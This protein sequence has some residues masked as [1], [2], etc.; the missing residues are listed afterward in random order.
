[1]HIYF[2]FICLLLLH[3]VYSV[4]PYEDFKDNNSNSNVIEQPSSQ[5]P[6]SLLANSTQKIT[7]LKCLIKKDN[8]NEDEDTCL[9]DL[10]RSPGCLGKCACLALAS[11]PAW[12]AGLGA[13]GLGALGHLL[14]TCCGCASCCG[15]Q[16]TYIGC[17]AGC[18]GIEFG[19]INL[20]MTPGYISIIQKA[21]SEKSVK[22]DSLTHEQI[23]SILAS[24]TELYNCSVCFEVNEEIGLHRCSPDKDFA[25][26]S[27]ICKPCFM[28]LPEKKCVIC[29]AEV[30]FP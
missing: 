28:K 20:L 23:N 9:R 18:G 27:S 11:A 3:R 25:L 19:G 2:F 15:C 6:T 4:T 7:E 16:T 24:Q 30:D 1:M 29:E 26:E 17:A 22:N 21:R 5:Q 12:L 14:Y 10:W 8:D 13:A